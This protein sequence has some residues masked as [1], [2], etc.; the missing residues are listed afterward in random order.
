MIQ[1]VIQLMLGV[2]IALEHKPDEPTRHVPEI[3]PLG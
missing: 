2:V 1:I 3:H